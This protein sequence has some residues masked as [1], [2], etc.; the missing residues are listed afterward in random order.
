MGLES[1]VGVLA[2]LVTTNLIC[3]IGLHHLLTIPLM[4]LSYGICTVQ[5][6]CGVPVIAPTIFS[7]IVG[8][9]EA[10]PHSYPWQTSLLLKQSSTWKHFCGGSIIGRRLVSTA[11]HC[12]S[13]I[14]NIIRIDEFPNNSGGQTFGTRGHFNFDQQ[15]EGRIFLL[16]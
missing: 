1:V 12:V 14:L 5:N 7:R 16:P 11:A 15:A 8:G 10:T 3:D 6:D 13:V 2:D 9:T 4:L